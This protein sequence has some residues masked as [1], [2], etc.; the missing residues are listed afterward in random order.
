MSPL[1]FQKQIRLQ[2]ARLLLAA[3]GGDITSVSYQVGY[4]SPAQFSREYRRHFG[5]SPSEDAAKLR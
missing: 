5:A 4:N 1:Q 3:G 2:E